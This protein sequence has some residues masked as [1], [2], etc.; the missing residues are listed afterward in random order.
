MAKG[1]DVPGVSQWSLETL[2]LSRRRFMQRTAFAGAAFAF[3]GL[4]AACGSDDD[5]G[6]ATG[7]TGSTE[8][9]GSTGGGGGEGETL[10]VYSWEGYHQPEWIEEFSSE[11]GITINITN[12][13]SPAEMF[14]KVKANPEQFDLILNTAGWF[15]QYVADDLLVPVDESAVPNVKQ[16]SDAF[17]WRDATSVDGT[18]YG[19]LYNWGDQPLGWN[20]D[21]IPGDYDISQYVD[22]DGVPNDWN[23]LWDSQFEGVVSVFDDPTSVEPMIPLALGLP[24]PFNLT[25]EQFSQFEQKLFE[26][27]P[28]IKR[29]TSGFD[30][31]TNAFVTE[32][33]LI[34]YLNNALSIVTAGEAG[35]SLAANH[36]VKQGTPAW[37]DNYAITKASGANKLDAIYEFVNASLTIPWQARF[38][39][40]SGNSGTLDY[41]QATS[42]EAVSAG[43]TEDKLAITL[44]PQTQAGETFFSSMVFFKAVEDLDRRIE[45]WDEFKLGIGS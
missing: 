30:D 42:E 5:G 33:A 32:E 20:A 35:T 16:I 39:A 9:T 26:L 11:S 12:V 23:I 18:N 31:Q 27:R 40:A 7:S 24:D 36:L 22:E 17:P 13:G 6:G 10:N 4:A 29:L 21:V 44:I 8:G 19:I 37:S 38:V 2:S 1:K 3:G 34:G 45:I 15:D 28:Q 25:E 41:E 43:L 14:S